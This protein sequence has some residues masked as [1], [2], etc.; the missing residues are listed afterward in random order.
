MKMADYRA[1]AEELRACT[2][3][4]RYRRYTALFTLDWLG[5]RG[6]HFG[7]QM[8]LPL[9]QAR[10]LARSSA[11]AQIMADIHLNRNL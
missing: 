10:A 3:E 4:T 11:K 1:A 2:I 6:D 7:F 8:N 5:A 9:E